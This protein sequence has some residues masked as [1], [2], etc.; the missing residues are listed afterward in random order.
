MTRMLIRV[1]DETYNAMVARTGLIFLSGV[2]IVLAV[3]LTL[4]LPP[5]S[6]NYPSVKRASIVDGPG[7]YGE[8]GYTAVYV[9]QSGIY[10]AAYSMYDGPCGPN[11]G[12]V[13]LQK[14]NLNDSVVWQ[15][16]LGTMDCGNDTQIGGIIGGPQGVYLIGTQL[17]GSYTSDFYQA[18]ARVQEFDRQS[19]KTI[20]VHHFTT[21][22]TSQF[23]S[24]D[25]GTWVYTISVAK[26]GI[27]IAGR[28]W[29]Q[30]VSDL[31]SD[32]NQPASNDTSAFI[33][34]YDL[35]GDL[36][37]SQ[38]MENLSYITGAYASDEGVYFAGGG[39]A[40]KYDI[41]G[42]LLWI[43]RFGAIPGAEAT[44]ASGDQTGVY[45]V[46]DL[47][48]Q[49]LV[50]KY[51]FHGDELWIHQIASQGQFGSD[52]QGLRV[53]AGVDGVYVAGITSGTLPGQAFTG[54]YDS[55]VRKYSTGGMETWTAQFGPADQFAVYVSNDGV[56]VVGSTIGAPFGQ[57]HNGFAAAFVVEFSFSSV[58]TMFGLIPPWSY[59]AAILLA[60]GIAGSITS[61]VH[62][63][64]ERRRER[65]SLG[66]VI[67]YDRP[68][69]SQATLVRGAFFSRGAMR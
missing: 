41:N 42:T 65:V 30:I 14:I 12:S 18:V 38:R 34:R 25:F 52:V 69:S 48:R 24:G 45:L 33:E 66:P 43:R 5:L 15:K 19:G 62:V 44:G 9:D 37:W 60:S 68:G 2:L 51:T 47:N 54:P 63:I 3:L 50:E 55:F 21:N 64:R 31:P 27:Y 29:G 35:A 39:L 59:L 17:Y 58:F 13:F 46:G 49:G 40:G 56:F 23:S 16:V 26:S 22:S 57:Q 11:K 28:A 4:Q 53:S 6:G 61:V 32:H 20:W 10:V 1:M 7:V 36:M 67:S 8:S